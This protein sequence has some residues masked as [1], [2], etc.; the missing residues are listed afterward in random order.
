MKNVL[1]DRKLR[2]ILPLAQMVLVVLLLRL[3]FLYDVATRYDDSPGVHPAF[4]LLLLV[5]FPVSV[6]LKLLLYGRLPPLW[7]DTVFVVMVGV[8]WSGVASCVLVYRKRQAVFPPDRAWLRVSADLLLITMGIFLVW[9]VAEELRDYPFMLSPSH[10]GGWL[11]FASVCISA[12]LW[13]V[14]SVLVFGYDLGNCVRHRCS[15]SKTAAL[16]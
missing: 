3:S 6:P 8:L 7:F 15:A 9:V 10:L 14:G 1:A 2:I 5:N 13:S 12:L 11:W 16:R 4:I